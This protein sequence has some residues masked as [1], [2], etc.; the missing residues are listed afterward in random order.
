MKKELYEL[1]KTDESIFDFI[2]ERALD[3]LWYWDLEKPENAWMDARF[4][5]VLG[6]NPDEMSHKSN[7]WQKITNQNDLKLAS[8]NFTRHCENPDHPY[9]QVVRYTHKDGSTV[10]IRWCGIAI[11][12]KNGKPVRMLGASQD[13]SDTKRSEQEFLDGERNSQLKNKGY[14]AINEELRQKNSELIKAHENAKHA[15]EKYTELYDFSPSG[16][17][18]ISK[19]GAISDLNLAA[20]RMLGKERSK[21]IESRLAL[22]ISD[23]TRA[24]F[25][26]FVQKVFTNNTK[27]S[28]ETIIATDGNWPIY[29]IIEGIVSA[30]DGL[31]HLTVVDITERKQAELELNESHKLFD[32]FFHGA[33]DGFFFMML[34]EPVEWNDNIDKEK[35]LDYVFS[36]QR[37]TKINDAM[38]QLFGAKKEDFLKLTP[39]DFFSHDLKHGRKVWKQFFDAGRL[40]IDTTEKKLDGDDLIINGSYT[41][42][43]DEKGRV[44]GHFG[45]Q[46]NVTEERKVKEALKESEEKTRYIL[47][48]NP[49]AIAVFDNEMNLLIVSDRFL[50][51][52]NVKDKIIIGRNHYDVF[53]EI[54]EKWRTIHKKALQGEVLSNDDDY[55]IRPDGSITYSRWECRPW[56][57]SDNSIG[58][59]IAYTEVITERKLA[60]LALKESERNLQLKNEEFEAI[61][62]ELR[63]TNYELLKSKEK[64]EESDRLKSAF[65]ANMSHEIRTPMNGILGFADLLKKPGLNGEKQQVYIDIIKKSGQ[66]MLNI[67]N[68]IIDISKIE[69]GLMELDINESDINEQIE[70]TYTFFKPEAEAKGMRLYYRNSLPAKEAVI[71]TDREKVYAILAN[72]VKNAIKYSEEGS[73]EMGY[74]LKTDSKPGELVFYVKDTGTGIPKERHEAIFDR[75][76]QADI[77]NKMAHQGAGL[78]LAITKAYVD[79]LGGKIWV[80][81][82]VGKGSIF[83][84]TLPYNANISF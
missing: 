5:K 12:D 71:K 13:L 7:A 44:T 68:D 17:L 33:L 30:D 81:S 66:R 55:F 83:Y 39:N 24:V 73:I 74:D 15:I 45:M 56:Y 21:L 61:N 78:G 26:L 67:I 14:E 27:Q 51:D 3:G 19:D 9:D 18:S 57:N 40:Q 47:K 34:D 36:H 80:D 63:Q 58:G 70:Y 43:Y 11:R 22:F 60:E 65:L 16:Y 32:M 54:P 38:L 41:L 31:C 28:C 50:A 53:P 52:Y 6:Y 76:I 62:E 59:M 77:T 8:D 23:E 75:F 49:N 25:N 72:L 82:E 46:R 69:V 20:A 2:H 84:F 42:L 35:A 48:H 1:I 4:W 10:W 64:A 37:I 79:M 29:V